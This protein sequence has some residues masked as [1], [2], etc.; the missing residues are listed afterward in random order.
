MSLARGW[1]EA[2]TTAAAR[3][4]GD[5]ARFGVAAHHPDDAGR[6]VLLDPGV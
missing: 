2:E 6:A 5:A 4:A 3:Y 1:P